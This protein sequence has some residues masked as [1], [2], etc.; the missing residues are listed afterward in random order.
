VNGAEYISEFLRLRG[1]NK[2][3]LITGGACAFMVDA[4]AR[5]DGLSYVCF[6]HEQAAAMAADSLWRIDK[7][8]GVT[9]VTSGPGATN[10]IT[11][12]ACSFFDSI[13]TIHLTGQVNQREGRK[14]LGANVRQAGFQETQIVD[15]VKPITKY[16]VEV[17]SGDELKAELTKAYN[18]AIS[19]RMGPVLIDVPMDVQQ[20]EV[21]NVVDYL[22][23]VKP[24]IDQSEKSSIVESLNEFFSGSE[25][26]VILFGAGIGLSGSEQCFEKWLRGKTI[27]FV[28]SWNGSR[29]FDHDLP[30]YYGSIG[31]YGNRGANFVLQNSDR[32]LVLGS[33]LD[34]RQ[35]SGEVSSFA[36]LAKVCV[37]DIDKD[38]LK[39]YKD[40]K[41]STLNYDLGGVVDIFDQLD[42]PISNDWKKFCESMKLEYFGICKSTSAEKYKSLSPYAVVKKINQL[43]KNNSIVVADDGANLCWVFQSFHRTQHNLYTAGGNSPMGYAFPAAIGAAIHKPEAQIIAFTGDGSMQINIQELQTMKNY[44]LNI[45][46]VIL[47]NFGYGIIKQFQDS[48]F[49]SR[50]EASGNGYSQPDFVAVS[51]AYGIACHVVETVDDLTQELINSTGP[52]IFDVRLHPNT[53]I[54]PKLEMGNP[55]NRQFPYLDESKLL[56]GTKYFKK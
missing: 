44:N 41:Y 46:L 53:L 12:I 23:P 54:E 15:M 2:I 45:K 26:P 22:A 3:F 35:T 47:N 34:N 7:T 31:V 28:S 30:N 13:P 27:P 33:R 25:R 38:E 37:V 56:E 48:Y 14:F 17:T 19:G 16:A 4:V 29:Y 43:I 5:N 18:I 36:P 52:A 50:Y 39:K 24:A 42:I 8:V 1:S 32:L 51:E 55:I 21:G 20:E 9:M 11:G 10:L 49:G 40:K 6:H